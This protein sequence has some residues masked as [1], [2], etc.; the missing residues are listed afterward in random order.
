MTEK[1]TKPWAKGKLTVTENG[2]YLRNG[3][4]PFFWLGDTAWLFF[5]RCTLEQA[6]IYLKNRKAK[7]FNVIQVDFQHGTTEQVVDFAKPLEGQPATSDEWNFNNPEYWKHCDAIIKM[8]E[9]LG[10]YMGLLPLWGGVYKSGLFTKKTI[11]DYARFLANRYQD[12]ENII[13]LVGG[14]VRGTDAPELFK[15]TGRVLKAENPDKL[16][17]FHP[18]GRTTSSAWFHDEPWMDFNMFQSGHRRYDQ[19]SLGSWDDNAMKEDYY[20]E[21]NWRYVLNDHSYTPMK[22]TVDGEPSY[23]LI[24]HGLHDESQPYWQDYDVRRYAWWSVLAGAMGHTYGDNAIMQF[25]YNPEEKGAFGVKDVW[26]DALH[27]VGS[28]HMKHMADFMNQI[29]FIN[30]RPADELLID[31]QKEKYDRISVFAGPDFIACYN[32]TGRAFSLDLSRYKGMKLAAYW[33]EPVS[34]IYSYFADVSNSEQVTFK[35]IVKPDKAND[36]VLLIKEEE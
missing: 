8:A 16:V 20:G 36:W 28:G 17:T 32:Y 19:S 23:E 14:D 12:Y 9:D 4:Q 6:E 11:G 33:F 21:D 31:G 13:W 25:H 30:G 35:P 7:G 29:D 3:D 26:Q 34:G 1:Q 27:H 2:R 5:P 24:L 18:F 22:P 15:E 10:L